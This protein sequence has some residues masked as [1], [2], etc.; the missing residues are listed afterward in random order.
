MARALPS[1]GLLNFDLTP[2]LTAITPGAI[3]TTAF[4]RIGVTLSRTS[5]VGLCQGTAV[6]ANAING[7]NTV[8]L[9]P[10]GIPPAF[11]ALSGVIVATFTGPV[12]SVCIDATPVLPLLPPLGAVLARPFLE[13]LGSDGSI[14]ARA[15]ATAT[16][17]TQSI[18]VS[19][20]AIAAVRFAGAGSTLARFDNLSFSRI[21]SP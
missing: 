20:A 11:S 15:T 16:P 6:Y 2:D 19:S 4:S 21:A 5:G 1:T 8:S 9:C 3:V 13:A 18:C 10:Q 12:A 7:T 17:Q 14:I